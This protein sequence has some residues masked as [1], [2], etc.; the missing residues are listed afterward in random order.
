MHF[1]MQPKLTLK[2]KETATYQHL[3]SYLS[4]HLKRIL[5]FYFK[6]HLIREMTKKKKTQIIL[7]SHNNFYPEISRQIVKTF[8]RFP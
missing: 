1:Q 6:S 3:P 2:Y 8:R 5:N 4:P 7:A